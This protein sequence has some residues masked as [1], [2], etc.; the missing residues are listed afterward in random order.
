M[1]SKFDEF[2]EDWPSSDDFDPI[3]EDFEKFL[4]L[5]A[6]IDGEVTPDE[7]RQVQQ[8]LDTDPQFKQQ[9]LQQ[10]RLQQGIS[11]TSVPNS[12]PPSSVVA[13]S[14]FKAVD[15]ENRHKQVLVGSSVLIAALF[16]VLVPHFLYKSA[17]SPN[18]AVSYLES[19]E[20]EEITVH[21]DSDNLVIALNQPIIELPADIQSDFK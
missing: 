2:N 19:G 14:V 9:Y 7:R 11:R 15:R 4:L 1:K 8:W 10:S 20:T 12:S 18:M 17:F 21:E 16:A 13:E 3:D 5:S 6:Y